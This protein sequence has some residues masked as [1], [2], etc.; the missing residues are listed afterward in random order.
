MCRDSSDGV[1]TIGCRVNSPKANKCMACSKRVNV[2]AYSEWSNV[3]IDTLGMEFHLVRSQP[4]LGIR[5]AAPQD[6][7]SSAEFWSRGTIYVELSSQ[8]RER[9][10]TLCDTKPKQIISRCCIHT[11]L[12]E[13]HPN[14]VSFL[15]ITVSFPFYSV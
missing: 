6:K 3:P 10:F 4:L 13:L 8:S 5:R 2:I 14:A 7:S 12:K 15:A 1:P 9:Q 11:F